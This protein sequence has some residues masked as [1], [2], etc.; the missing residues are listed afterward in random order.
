MASNIAK[1]AMANSD[2]DK[3]LVE[4][5][6]MWRDATHED[7]RW[8]ALN[9]YAQAKAERD[10]AAKAAYNLEPMVN[11]IATSI[12]S[13]ISGKADYKIMVS[14]ISKLRQEKLDALNIT[15]PSVIAAFNNTFNQMEQNA[16]AAFNAE[17]ARLKKKTALELTDEQIANAGEAAYFPLANLNPLQAGIKFGQD[18]TLAV[19]TGRQAGLI[20]RADT[21]PVMK[22]SVA[23]A[24]MRAHKQYGNGLASLDTALENSKVKF[25]D[26]TEHNLL[27]IEGGRY[28]ENLRAKMLAWDAQQAEFLARQQKAN[29]DATKAALIEAVWA[30]N[31]VG[32]EDERIAAE[33]AID[34]RFG[35]ADVNNLMGPTWERDR[36]VIAKNTRADHEA[37][38]QSEFKAGVQSAAYKGKYLPHM[39]DLSSNPDEWLP[40]MLEDENLTSAERMA[41]RAEAKLRRDLRDKTTGRDHRKKFKMDILALYAHQDTRQEKAFENFNEATGDF[42][43]NKVLTPREKQGIY[44]FEQRINKMYE[45][46]AAEDDEVRAGEILLEIDQQVDR[47]FDDTFGTSA[48]ITQRNQRQKEIDASVQ[49]NLTQEILRTG[50]LPDIV[51]LPSQ[52]RK[53]VLQSVFSITNLEKQHPNMSDKE[54]QMLSDV[55]NRV[56]DDESVNYLHTTQKGLEKLHALFKGADD[57]SKYSQARA[58]AAAET[59]AHI[60]QADIDILAQSHTIADLEM[61]SRNAGELTKVHEFTTPRR[62]ASEITTVI[63]TAFEPSIRRDKEVLESE[64]E[65]RIIR[66]GATEYLNSIA[67][68]LTTEMLT[69][70]SDKWAETASQIGNST[71]ALGEFTKAIHKE[72]PV[73]RARDKFKTIVGSTILSEPQDVDTTLYK[74]LTQGGQQG[75]KWFHLSPDGKTWR[76]SKLPADMAAVSKFL[77]DSTVK[78]SQKYLKAAI[79]ED[80]EAKKAHARS[81]ERSAG[82]ATDTDGS[83]GT[84]PAET[85]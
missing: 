70:D 82:T 47:F 40:A 73:R 59:Q 37:S 56:I 42:T 63:G 24:L 32:D 31:E 3:D 58:Q 74:V 41:G 55:A 12:R 21:F 71:R 43:E 26:G 44:N 85:P 46:F 23:S 50:N 64:T 11:D 6:K 68:T 48:S 62:F 20:M 10:L 79:Q 52:V 69:A 80:K 49:A 76:F 81:Q 78:P 67:N 33:E 8:L 1:D 83:T 36:K 25:D 72:Q 30:A 19:S 5:M 84:T 16:I 7:E 51:G 27:T 39:N 15:D 13:A 9:P 29:Q 17:S 45:Q 2:P 54:R 57:L 34:L 66:E 65:V 61:L 75:A 18:V 4:N 14:E 28:A 53:G 77:I 60:K 38:K 35:N 22:Q